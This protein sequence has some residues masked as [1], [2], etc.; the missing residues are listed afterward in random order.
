[1]SEWTI[2]AAQYD[3]RSHDIAH[4]IATHLRFIA[5]A[6]RQRCSLLLFPELSLTGAANV[7]LPLRADSALLQPLSQAAARY[8]MTVIAGVPLAADGVSR[9][10]V[11]V[12]SPDAAAPVTFYQG[13]GT[14]LSPHP[15]GAM[16]FPAAAEGSELDPQASLLATGTCTCGCQQQQSVQRLQRLAH[17]YAITVLKANYAGGSALWDDNGQL[18]VRA[19]AGELLLVGRR[20]AACWEGDIIPLRECL[21]P[22]D[23]IV[24][25]A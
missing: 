3:D 8:Q 4:N 12:F 21:S 11:A 17:K 16:H 5:A 6:A 1:M 9:A 7:I 13:C 25:G 19:D 14:C 10:G 22:I 20:R 24:C 2:A 15:R 23:E 18:I